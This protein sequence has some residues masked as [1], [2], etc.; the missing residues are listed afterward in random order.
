MRKILVKLKEAGLYTKPEKCKFS[1][2]KTTFLGF[3][4]LANRI[5]MDPVKVDAIYT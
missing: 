5:E 2:E 3:I 4:I 1:I